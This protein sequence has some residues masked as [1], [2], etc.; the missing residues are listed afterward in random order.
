MTNPEVKFLYIFDK[1]NPHN[2]GYTIAYA[3]ALFE[4][5]GQRTS[6]MYEVAVAYCSKKDSFDR[7]IGR[8]LAFDN[9]QA[10]QTILVPAGLAGRDY[11]VPFLK[12]MFKYF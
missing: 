3:P 10:G 12:E 9:F 2:G 11:V 4:T 6:K 8:E 5:K 7:K 1:T